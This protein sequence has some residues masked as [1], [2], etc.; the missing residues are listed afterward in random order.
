MSDLREPDFVASEVDQIPHET[1]DASSPGGEAPAVRPR[2]RP[3]REPALAA[4]SIA[5]AT[6]PSGLV[7]AAARCE[8]AI[9]EARGAL[10]NVHAPERVSEPVRDEPAAAEADVAPFLVAALGRAGRAV[11]GALAA[12]A[13]FV[14]VSAAQP[15]TLVPGAARAPATA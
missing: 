15:I 8:V 4:P 5:R 2:A 3:G 6:I 10:V 11:D 12:L 1:P 13:A 14:H 7:H 9:V